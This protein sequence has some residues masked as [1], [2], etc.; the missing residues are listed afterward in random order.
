MQ[1]VIPILLGLV[2]ILLAILVMIFALGRLRR[3]MR[4][5]G[6]ERIAIIEQVDMDGMGTLALLRRDDV[7]HL[8][9]I[10]E[11]GGFVIENGISAARSA[12]MADPRAKQPQPAPVAS[13]PAAPREPRVAP[14]RPAPEAR[15]DS[16]AA[17]A[18]NTA[19]Q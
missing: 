14:P 6:G 1:G 17:P 12:P 7:E 15:P 18:K 19:T 11:G 3:G 16:A 4:H 13:A 8:V 9:F 10:G 5:R 2:V